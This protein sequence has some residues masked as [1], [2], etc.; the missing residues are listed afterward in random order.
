MKAKLG[1]K[2]ATMADAPKIAVISH[3][4]VKNQFE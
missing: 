4:M 3:T 1:S 2:A